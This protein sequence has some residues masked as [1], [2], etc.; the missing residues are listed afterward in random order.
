VSSTD[1]S[2]P[3]ASL[4]NLPVRGLVT[5][6]FLSHH[7]PAAVSRT[8]TSNSQLCLRNQPL[9]HPRGTFAQKEDAENWH[10]QVLRP[11]YYCVWNFCH[12]IGQNLAKVEKPTTAEKAHGTNRSPRFLH[13]LKPSR[14]FSLVQKHKQPPDEVREIQLFEI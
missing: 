13:I 6:P 8:A 3:A 5:T 9:L 4:L 2:P 14:I 7:T 11:S 12:I 1:G 10:I